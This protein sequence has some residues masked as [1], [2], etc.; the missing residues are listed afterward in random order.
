[1]FVEDISNIASGNP[2]LDRS[3]CISNNCFLEHINSR[4]GSPSSH[5]LAAPPKTSSQRALTQQLSSQQRRSR[6]LLPSEHRPS[7]AE[8]FFPPSHLAQHRLAVFSATHNTAQH[9]T[10]YQATQPPIQV[11]HGARASESG[12]NLHARFPFPC[13]GRYHWITTCTK[14]ISLYC[15]YVLFTDLKVFFMTVPLMELSRRALRNSLSCL[16]HL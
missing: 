15:C 6:S 2:S 7:S 1:M 4:V 11:R 9:S 14:M 13:I 8:P 10:D 3:S 16:L 12:K 5:H